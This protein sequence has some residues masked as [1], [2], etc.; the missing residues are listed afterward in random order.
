MPSSIQ[1]H[2]QANKLLLILQWLL[3]LLLM[4]ALTLLYV[5][6]LRFE[7]KVNERFQGNEQVITRLNEM[8][9]RLF[10]SAQQ[11][12]PAPN[13]LVGSQAQNQ[14]DLLRIQI[15][16]VDRLLADSNHTAAIDLL[17]GLQ[18]QLSQ[19]SNEIA[20]ALTVVIQQ[21][22]SEDIARLQAQSQ[23]PSAWQLH[24]LAIQN[25]QEFLYSYERIKS[26]DT[27]TRQ[28]LTI[29]EVIMTLNLAIQASNM[30]D[31]E[32]LISHLRQARGQLQPLVTPSQLNNL[33][34]LDNTLS[35]MPV[36]SDIPEVILWLD[37]LVTNAPT[38]TVLLTTQ[39]LNKPER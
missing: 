28:Q 25:I 27:L 21:S 4:V 30:R 1:Q 10:A 22:L 34:S 26:D 32:Q 29:H 7:N 8:D 2:K 23:Q 11:S 17:Q 5:S 14:L 12:L 35:T 37:R 9:D 39:I 6:H 38:P 16:A 33:P 20:P 36:P 13:A 31:Q 19:S 15:Q 18:W 3:I 24:N